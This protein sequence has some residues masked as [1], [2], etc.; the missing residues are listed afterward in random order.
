MAK[1]L[2]K[3]ARIRRMLDRGNSVKQIAAA[4]QCT[5]QMVYQIRAADNKKKQNGAPKK[6]IIVPGSFK[7]YQ[8]YTA[9]EVPKDYFEQPKR[10]MWTRFKSWLGA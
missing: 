9:H 7:G 10:S 2:T 6:D 5:P 4:V 1:K 3:S 8:P